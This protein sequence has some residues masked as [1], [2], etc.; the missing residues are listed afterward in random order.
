MD[1][2]QQV[3]TTNGSIAE[4]QKAMDDL[5]K[6][7]HA[8]STDKKAVETRMKD[9]GL[10][11][12]WDQKN[13]MSLDGLP[14]LAN[15]APVSGSSTPVPYGRIDDDTQA[16]RTSVVNG[17]ADTQKPL[18]TAAEVRATVMRERRRLSSNWLADLYIWAAL[19]VL[20]MALGFGLR[21]PLQRVL[22]VL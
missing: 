7:A 20:G 13:C 1:E 4:R 5:L 6:E 21:V 15:L 2:S 18:Y 9:K 19:L 16:S 3:V 22:G 14:G 8:T 11:Q 17:N 10:Q 12:Y